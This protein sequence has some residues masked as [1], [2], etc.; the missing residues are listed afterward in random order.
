MAIPFKIPSF[1][2]QKGWTMHN[3]G[4][5]I[6]SSRAVRYEIKRGARAHRL[7]V[8]HLLG[9]AIDETMHVHHQDFDKTNNTPENLILLPAAMNPS[10]ALRDPF[11]GEF[12][13]KA[14][15]ERRYR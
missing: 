8:E 10:G 4:Y 14:Q 13:S 5:V 11:T 1:L 6:F 3:K 15:Y 2:P 9:D 12:L 7:V